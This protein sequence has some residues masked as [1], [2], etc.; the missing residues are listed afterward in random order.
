MFH[1]KFFDSENF[2]YFFTTAIYVIFFFNLTINDGSDRSLLKFFA[3]LAI[4][5]FFTKKIKIHTNLYF[6]LITITPFLFISLNEII[7]NKN[8]IPSNQLAWFSHTS[9]LYKFQ[10]IY[11]LFFLFLPALILNTKFCSEV[12]FK[13]I[14][15][16]VLISIPFNI[17]INLSSHFDR[18]LI[19]KEL[20]PVILYDYSLIAISLLTFC[21]GFY[22]KNKTAYIFIFLSLIN[23]LLIC[24]H[25]TRG[26]WLGIPIIFLIVFIIFYKKNFLKILTIFG[27][28]LLLI[29]IVLM[30]PNNPIQTRLQA[31]KSDEYNIVHNQNYN[32]S[33][34]TRLSLWEL[35]LE[36]FKEA[37]LTG[38]GIVQFKEDICE[39]NRQGKIGECTIHAHN[40]FFQ[41]LAT[42]GLLGILALLTLLLLPLQFFIQSLRKNSNNEE[43]R[44]LCCAGISFIV[45]IIIC[46][47]TDFY[48]YA[49]RQTILY[50]LVIFT[51]MSL[52]L[53]NLQ[54]ES[55][56]RLQK[57]SGGEFNN[58]N[59]CEEIDKE[60]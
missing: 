37:P 34:G 38:I 32:T 33:V 54:H 27:V 22:K 11:T 49:P 48:F 47:L 1:S 9:E 59:P 2:I 41:I 15:I 29:A 14:N 44:L 57:V 10:F 30:I 5:F 43:I 40:I 13:I 17:Y 26:A 45:Y 58:V 53:K 16:T 7:I 19:A 42:Q 28:S 24:L 6:I 51:L 55:S 46:G 23:I 8:I 12:F 36:K 60:A 4:L 52:I 25:G 50:Y 56:N 21:Y 20:N 3:F 31:L 18:D 35:S 39:L